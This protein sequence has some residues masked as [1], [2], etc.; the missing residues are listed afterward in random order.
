MRQ[1]EQKALRDKL[2]Q[3]EREVNEL[4]KSIQVSADTK[5]GGVGMKWAGLA[6]KW[7]R[8]D[9]GGGRGLVEG[10]RGRGR[11]KNVGRGEE[12]V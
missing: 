10:G 12:R 1:R 3:Q 6:S 11:Q 2:A 8:E 4:K 5:V 9:Q 7:M